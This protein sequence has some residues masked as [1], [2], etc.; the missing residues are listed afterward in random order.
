MQQNVRNSKKG[1]LEKGNF[2]IKL[3]EI[4]FQIRDKFAHPSADVRNEIPAICANWARNLR[5]ICATPPFANAPFSQQKKGLPLPLGRGVCE[6]KSKNGRSRVQT[7]KTFIS[8][9]FCAQRR[10]ETMVSDHGLERGQ[11]MG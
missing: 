6:T 2:C 11:T 9:V 4:D 8:R 10:I 5:Q 1:A 7:Q 3:S